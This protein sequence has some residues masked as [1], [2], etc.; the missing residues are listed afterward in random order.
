MSVQHAID[1]LKPY[2]KNL[3]DWDAVY[4]FLGVPYVKGVGFGRDELG[5]T[6]AETWPFRAIGEPKRELPLPST[7][8]STLFH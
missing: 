7:V 8:V 1:L 3:E 2:R 5:V 4:E 6:T